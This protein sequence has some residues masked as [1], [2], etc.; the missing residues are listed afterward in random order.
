[1]DVHPSFVDNPGLSDFDLPKPLYDVVA[2]QHRY[3]LLLTCSSVSA[4]L[5]PHQTTLLLVR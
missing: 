1:M 4:D 5:R 2:K 3:L